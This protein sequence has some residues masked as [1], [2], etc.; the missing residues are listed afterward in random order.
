[1][2]TTMCWDCGK[3][4]NL[5]DENHVTRSYREGQKVSYTFHMSCHDHLQ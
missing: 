5:Q 4:V 1:M 2:K 3:P